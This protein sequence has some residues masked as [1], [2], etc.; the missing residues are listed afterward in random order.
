MRI[1]FMG[2]PDF[3]AVSLRAL[4]DVNFDVWAVF[5]MPDRP[6]NRGHKK[7]PSP[8]KALAL[9][10]GIE[11]YEPTSL[12]DGTAL[13]LLRGINPDVIA[14]VAYGR[15]LPV[16]ILELPRL[17]CVNVHA[18]LLPKYRGAAPIQRAVLNGDAMTGVT[19]MYMGEG[20]DTGDMIYRTETEIGE[21]ETSG[22]LFERLAPIGAEL[23]AKTLRDV[24]AGTAP[25]EAQNEAEAT[26]APPLDKSES[27]I[28][29][30]KSPREI[31]KH[32]M[33][34]QPWPVATATLG[35]TDF[36]IYAAE[37]VD[38]AHGKKPGSVIEAGPKHG[39]EVACGD[40]SVIITELQV[41]GGRRMRA[42]D[43]LLGHPIDADG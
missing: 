32:V 28:S 4:T 39:I 15:I 20:L 31:V 33:G 3:A 38:A 40:G 13:E 43:Y 22:E 26:Y 10:R 37:P 25:R 27:P 21:F 8:V 34:M 17:G 1:V 18:S 19:T 29:W 5:T 6:R 35:G 30:D 24:D 41:S 2:T 16:E 23:L 36:K 42:R 7:A 14:V 9:E 12:R 11:V